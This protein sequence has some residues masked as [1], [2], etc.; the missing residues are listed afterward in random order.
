MPKLRPN[1]NTS[2]FQYSPSANIKQEAYADSLRLT[3]PDIVMLL[4]KEAGQL[5][6]GDTVPANK[7]IKLVFG[8]VKTNY[9]L[10]LTLPH[11]DK[12]IAGSCVIFSK[13]LTE[14][15]I[16]VQTIKAVPVSELSTALLIALRD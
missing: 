5:I 10:C 11:N 13:D 6:E 15:S 9:I 2:S 8:A 1:Q 3:G 16:T 12:Y 7:A 4:G 14:L